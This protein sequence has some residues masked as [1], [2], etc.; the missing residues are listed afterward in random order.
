MILA[1]TADGRKRAM[2][3]GVKFGRRPKLSA[4]QIA[5]AIRRR[6][7][8]E[9]LA[10]I[11]RSYGVT[12][13]YRGSG[14]AKAREGPRSLGSRRR[15]FQL[16][17]SFTIPALRPPPRETGAARGTDLRGARFSLVFPF[18]ALHS[19]VRQGNAMPGADFQPIVFSMSHWS[20]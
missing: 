5:E 2:D 7:A 3:R 4:F 6:D 19:Q 9:P 15:P 8:G 16:A 11:G 1:R 14:D 20:S 12:R 10:D 13:R 18:T 17:W